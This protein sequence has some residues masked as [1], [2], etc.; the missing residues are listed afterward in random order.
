MCDKPVRRFATVLAVIASILLAA[1][2]VASAAAARRAPFGLFGVVLDPALPLSA[3]GALDSQMA[4]M[5]QS[6]VESVRTDFDWSATEPSPGRY[7]WSTT[8]AIVREASMHGLQLLPIIEFTPSWASS[9]RGSNFQFYAPSNPNT[10]ASFATQ[11][12][13]RYGPH[14]SFWAANRAVPYAPIRYWQVWNEP[15]GT[16]YDWRSTPWPRTYTRLLKATYRAIHRADRGA[17]VVSGALVSLNGTNLTPWA[18]ATSLY[19]AG[20]RGYFD[21]LAVNTFTYSPSITKT[22][23]YTVEIASRVRQM[24]RAYHD[25]S[26]PMWVTEV[27]WTAAAGKIPKTEYGGFETTPKGQAQRLTAYYKEIATKH[28]AGIQR[29]FWYTWVSPYVDRQILG[30]PPTFQYSGLVKWQPGATT[31]QPLPVL[32][33]Y[34]SVA[35]RFEGCRKSS[36]AR[37]CR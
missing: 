35:A 25:G 26:R 12:I 9:H 18:E 33:A 17:H 14:G 8:D 4:L 16:K 10:Y 7:D 6:G 5:A 28:P 20:F 36:N 37:R 19:R 1:G 32:S 31:F 30:N 13:R 24:M 3:P 34:A 23:A 2:S 29:A 27:T 21:I 22:I 11:L 15:E